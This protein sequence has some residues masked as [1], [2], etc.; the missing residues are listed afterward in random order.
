MIVAYWTGA[1]P[2]EV[3]TAV[4]PP[5][6]DGIK[7][8]RLRDFA[9]GRGLAAYLVHGEVADLEHEVRQGRPVLVGL[10]KPTGRKGYVLTHYEVVVG[11]HPAR[12]V[13]VTLDPA[14]GWRQNSLDGFLAEWKPA[15][16]LALVV[17]GP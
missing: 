3:R 7:A 11:Y 16:R 10:A 2:V 6:R 14:L 1:E 4:G 15:G 8:G 17:S 13:V 12:R 9:R 5:S